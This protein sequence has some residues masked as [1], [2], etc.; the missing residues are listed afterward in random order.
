MGSPHRSS[1]G[2][3]KRGGLIM[4]KRVI[5]VIFAALIL[6]CTGCDDRTITKLDISPKM[7]MHIYNDAQKR[8]IQVRLGAGFGYYGGD[9]AAQ[10]VEW[11]STNPEVATI[12]AKAR[13]DYEANY[14][15]RAEVELHAKG[16]AE[17]YA[18]TVDGSVE[19]DHIKLMYGKRV[20]KEQTTP[21]DE[22]PIRELKLSKDGTMKVQSGK[23][24]SVLSV[25]ILTENGRYKNVDAVERIQWVSTNPE[26]AEVTSKEPGD[27]DPDYKV[28]AEF[29]MLSEGITEVYAQT[30]DGEVVSDPVKILYGNRF[31]KE[32]TIDYDVA[33]YIAQR[34]KYPT[35][36]SREIRK[37]RPSYIMKNRTVFVYS[38]HTRGSEVQVNELSIDG[39]MV[40]A[41]GMIDTFNENGMKTKCN[42]SLQL[43]YNDGFTEYR[44]ISQQYGA[45]ELILPESE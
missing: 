19:S 39:H 17:L 37:V 9:D 22:S 3:L 13:T 6:L 18:R 35:Q 24:P 21:Y 11:V 25:E 44:V 12:S 29:A 7:D 4:K 16:T 26:V 23:E 1:L 41:E 36:T 20:V 28:K 31:D 38:D 5:C 15:L 8:Q 2:Y 42:F 40:K 33:T 27:Y 10:L 30:L 34:L 32:K 14:V 45:P 43:E